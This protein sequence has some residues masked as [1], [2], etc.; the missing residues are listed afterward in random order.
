MRGNSGFIGPKQETSSSSVNGVFDIYDQYRKRT[1]D[2]WSQFQVESITGSNG[3]TANE[4]VSTTFTI[5]TSGIADGTTLYYSL[6]TLSGTALTS[7]DFSIGD[8]SGSFSITSDSG[9]F[10][11][12]PTGDGLAESN[13]FRIHIRRGSISGDILKSSGTFTIADAAVQSGNPSFTWKYHAYGSS[14]NE[15]RFYWVTSSGTSY[16]LTTITG[17]QHTSSGASWDSYTQ[18]LS[19]YSGQTGRIYIRYEQGSSF[20]QDIAFDDMSLNDTSVGNVDHDPGNSTGRGRWQKR[21]NGSTTTS[22]PP[23]SDTF[24]AVPIG[25]STSNQ[26]NFDSGGTPSGSTGP[27]TDASGSSAGYYLY[28]EGSSP[29]YGTAGT[30]FWLRMSADYTLL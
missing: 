17:Q 4:G 19:S 10:E 15:T 27:S 2:N 9:S 22:T 20:T 29:N 13:T 28:F 18:N 21:S 30:Y 5:S 23:T 24:N 6:E 12:R 11:L 7:A 8:V 16:L 1:D 14:I 3:T 25:T 26:W